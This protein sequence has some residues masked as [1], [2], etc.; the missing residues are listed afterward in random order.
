MIESNVQSE[1]DWWVLGNYFKSCEKDSGQWGLRTRRLLGLVVGESGG[2]NI[3]T[4]RQ[5]VGKKVIR[6]QR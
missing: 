4:R 1:V 5:R 2:G 3:Q 6:R